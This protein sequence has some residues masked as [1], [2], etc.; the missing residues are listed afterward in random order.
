MRNRFAAAAVVAFLPELD[1]IFTSVD[2]QITT[3]RAFFGGED[4]YTLI[5]ADLARLL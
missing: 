4:V 3:L 5:L 2:E 1:G